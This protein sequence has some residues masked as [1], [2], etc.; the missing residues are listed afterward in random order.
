MY[1]RVV[2]RRCLGLFLLLGL[3]V[4][5]MAAERYTPNELLSMSVEELM[6][7]KV[8]TLSKR[9]EKYM[10]TAGA[11]FIITSDDIRRSGAR[12]IPDALRLSP[13]L[14]VSQTNMNQWQIGIRGQSDFFTD[15]LLVMVDGR[16][17][18]TT[19]FSGVWWG[20]QNY[21]LEDIKRIEIVRGP[22]GAIWGSNAVNGVINI[23][24][25]TAG[26]SPGLRIT[27]GGGTED[28]G[29][30]NI[31]Y[32]SHSGHVDYRIY[33]MNEL[34][35]GGLVP[36]YGYIGYKAGAN[37]PDFRR[38]NQNGF[39]MDWQADAL[40]K[41]TLHG[42]AYQV[43]TGVVNFWTPNVSTNPVGLTEVYTG[44]NEFAGR[45]LV[46][47]MEKEISPDITLKSQLIYDQYKIH[48]QFLRE[49]KDTYDADLQFDF[50]DVMNQNISVGMDLRRMISHFNN[51]PQ[52]KMPSRKTAI[53]SFFVND[54]LKLF[55]GL[56]RIIGGVK[57]E[58]NSY[59]KWIS[60]PSV[61][62]VISDDN[63]ALWSSVA[64]S[65]RTPND[66]ENGLRWNLRATSGPVTPTN[67]TGKYLLQQVGNGSAKAEAVL[68]YEVGGRLRPDEKSLIEITAFQIQYRGVL[69]TWQDKKNAANPFVVNGIMPEYLTNVLNGR[70]DGIEAN[71][72]YQPQLWM[73]LKGSYTYLHQVYSAYPISDGE[74]K[75]TVKTNIGQDPRHRFHVGVSLNPAENIEFDTNL[76]YTGSF[77]EGDISKYHRLD[78]RLA[79]RPIKNLELTLVGQD[80]LR[81]SY[82]SN[83]DSIMGLS[84]R[85]Q[86]RYY[87]QATYTIE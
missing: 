43:K 55:D 25:K 9:E 57:T 50:A 34:R 69:D 66:M 12:S 24:T 53:T 74:T 73:T 80:M 75:W 40:T 28:K 13:G 67:P 41:V 39:R 14:Q 38:L 85:I 54:E 35:D 4:D 44:L 32:G 22:G 2:L 11:V 49:Q 86:Q 59:T 62:A 6:N 29:F 20:V 26:Q 87:A 23:I 3:P 48:S 63:W 51:T 19:T 8:T 65:V 46:L 72:R 68:T 1:L 60:Q 21:P 30:G 37:A 45:N 71:F 15:L 77:R 78:M 5:G 58:R 84:S 64:K 70:G 81:S 31:S 7:V 56:V 42:D 79:W 18:Y 82:Q 61:R 27:A 10:G 83:N 16:P 36:N 76:Y 17:I 47:R 52:F 33:A